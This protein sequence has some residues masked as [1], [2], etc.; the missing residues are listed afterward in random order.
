MRLGILASHQG[1]NFQAI[2]DACQSGHLSAKIAVAI[3]NNGKSVALERARSASIP[4]VHLSSKSHPQEEELDEAILTTLLD[5]QVDLV[6]TVGYMKKLGP[7]TLHHYRQKII[8]IHPSLLPKYGGKGMFGMNVHKAV[9]AS[10]DKETGITVHY[11]NEN[12]DSGPVISQTRVPIVIDDT[13][14]SLAAR[15]LVE[16]HKLLISTLKQLTEASN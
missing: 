14:E 15:V 1:T 12:Y 13:P 9:L 16:E 6:V 8:N 5:H 7:K 4:A 10:D 11:V 3:S 2:I